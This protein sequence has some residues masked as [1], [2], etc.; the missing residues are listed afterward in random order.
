LVE[1]IVRDELAGP[2]VSGSDRRGVLGPRYRLRD[3]RRFEEASG[4]S[5]RSQQGKYRV[6][7]VRV[8][9]A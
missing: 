1:A 2:I 8:F 9:V 7:E 3:D 4:R 5:V 6:S